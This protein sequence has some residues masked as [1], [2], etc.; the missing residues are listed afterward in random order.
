MLTTGAGIAKEDLPKRIV[1]ATSH[2]Q[3]YY[4]AEFFR[5]HKVVRPVDP[6][7][8]RSSPRTGQR[9]PPSVAVPSSSLRSKLYAPCPIPSALGTSCVGT[10]AA[11]LEMGPSAPLGASPLGTYT[12]T[13]QRQ[14]A[15]IA[16][17]VD[18]DSS[19]L[20]DSP[21][22]REA[23]PHYLV[24]DTETQDIL[25]EEE[26][27]IE[28]APSPIILLSWQVLDATGAC[29]SEET[30]LIRRSASITEEATALHGIT[31][32]QMEC[33]ARSYAPHWSACSK[34]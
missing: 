4:L 11:S 14:D 6:K 12:S 1:G 16:V 30:H 18:V 26:V 32:E 21:A 29:L 2:D 22:P 27:G 8:W 3:S 28:F 25:H 10:P 7:N 13:L 24:L 19:P 15:P 17:E 9:Q 23:L 5:R 20:F 34:P 31:T 33:E